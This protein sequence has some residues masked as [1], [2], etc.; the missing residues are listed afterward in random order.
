VRYV[1]VRRRLAIG[2]GLATA[3]LLLL[4]W[5]ITI[6]AV[7]ASTTERVIIYVDQ[8]NPAANDSNPG[9]SS[10]PLE[11]IGRA[12]DVAAVYNADA[13]Q[14]EVLI[15]PG[16]Y[17]ESVE[18]SA[19][20]NATAAPIALRGVDAGVVISG[21]DTWEGWTGNEGMYSRAWPHEWGFAS[22]LPEWPEY[23]HAYLDANS[24]IRRREMVFIDRRPLTQ[25]MSLVDMSSTESSFFVS[26][27][28]NQI[29]INIPS[30]TE[31]ASAHVEVAIRPNLLVVDSMQ[32]VSIENLTF[33]HAAS[34]FVG[35]AVR[36]QRSQ[37]VRLVTTRFIW[38]NARGLGI[39]ESGA[40][41]IQNAS[42]LHNGIGGFTGYRVHDLR[43]VDSE[44]SYNGWRGARGW[45]WENHA[46]AVDANFID[47]ATG[48]K[49]FGLRNAS[50]H[51]YRAI[52]NLTG[53]L[54]LDFDNSGV[55]LDGLALGGNMTHGLFLEASQGPI[56]VVRSQICHNETGV[57]IGNASNVRLADNV[58]AG[59]ELG[60]VYLVGAKGPRFVLDHETGNQLSVRAEDW[61]I[62]RNT[63][64]VDDGNLALGTVLE[65]DLWYA[66]VQSLTAEDN[67]YS[68]PQQQ[69]VFQLSG[70]RN[71]SFAQWRAETGED[72]GSTFNSRHVGCALPAGTFGTSEER[73]TWFVLMAL[74]STFAVA[75]AF[76]IV[77]YRRRRR[78]RRR[79]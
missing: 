18:L 54:W 41:T 27:E 1:P 30:K 69:D 20:P 65:G 73:P 50:F 8:A 71:V 19:D 40:I 12:I 48:Q 5:T 10:A 68:S 24:I 9:T 44:A 21:S 51:S 34:P 46:S 35:A 60:Q 15:S 4:V 3:I 53:G 75:V 57:L 6:G 59:N 47:F 49:F 37:N 36:I 16:V 29:L 45:D 66:F 56:S 22:A 43:V 7:S 78:R 52:G 55:V 33:Q 25:V 61:D 63:I 70:A 23:V 2:S 67:R 42:A 77:T 76:A 38:N 79:A 11:T 14:V 72:A 58:L 32:N 28:N 31:I 74:V 62:E 26:E 17:R 39:S 13:V 64:A